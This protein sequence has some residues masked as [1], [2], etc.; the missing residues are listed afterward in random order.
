MTPTITLPRYTCLRC[1]YT[2]I[3]RVQHR[4]VRCAH[5]RSEYWHTPRSRGVAKPVENVRKP[6]QT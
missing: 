1:G 3:P 4:P 6:A 5:C 2:W